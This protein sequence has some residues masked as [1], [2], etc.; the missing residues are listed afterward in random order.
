MNT[1]AKI[2]T[3]VWA[4]R[5]SESLQQQSVSEGS[6]EGFRP[7][8]IYTAT[9]FTLYQRVAGRRTKSRHNMCHLRGF[10]EPL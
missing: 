1:A 3:S 4:K 10:R 7:D 9:D 2:V 6:R 5:L 8:K